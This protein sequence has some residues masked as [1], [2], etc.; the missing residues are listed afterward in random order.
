MIAAY[1]RGLYMSNGLDDSIKGAMMGVGL[2]EE[3]AR[4]EIEPYTGLIAVAAIN[5]PPSITLSGD[6]KGLQDR[7]VNICSSATSLPSLPFAPHVS[8]CSRLPASAGEAYQ[9][10]NTL[11]PAS[12]VLQC[13]RQASSAKFDGSA[14]LG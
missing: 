10:H 12:H 14:V 9:I 13:H 11:S 8:A 3:Q 1:Y 2:T 7:K 4:V 6:K 5:S